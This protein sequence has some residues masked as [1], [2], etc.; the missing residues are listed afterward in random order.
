MFFRPFRSRP[1]DYNE[2]LRIFIEF[3]SALAYLHEEFSE[4]ICIIHR[5]L[6]PDN[7]GFTLNYRLKLIDFGLATC[8]PKNEKRDD[9][10]QLTGTTGSFR[11]MAN[12][13]GMKEK[14]NEKVD[15]YSYG[16]IFYEAATGVTP[17]QNLDKHNFMRKVHREG[18]RP[19]LKCD[20]MGRTINL[21]APLVGLIKR[22]WDPVYQNRPSAQE[23]HST[24]SDYRAEKII[25]EGSTICGKLKHFLFSK[26]Y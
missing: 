17:F 11:Y 8:I 19:S 21:G 7:I 2:L 3:A 20:A 4:S 9:V 22:C 25:K 5:D 6:K 26:S 14:Y 10:Y 15:V 24:L 23:V 18:F 12:E 13:V 1:F 16:V